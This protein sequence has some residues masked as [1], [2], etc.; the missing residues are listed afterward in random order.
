MPD[1]TKKCPFCAETIKAEA[2]VCRYC[3]NE[4]TAKTNENPPLPGPVEIPTFES[5][6]K[7]KKKKSIVKRLLLA[8]A[9]STVL[10]CLG[11]IVLVALFGSDSGAADG[12]ANEAAAEETGD[13]SETQPA[14]ATSAPKLMLEI[15][16]VTDYF[17][18]NALLSDTALFFYGEVVNSG[19]LP[20]AEPEVKITLLDSAG[21]IIATESSRADLP[22]T[23][24]MWFTGVLY[25]GEKAP[26]TIVVADPGE[27]ADFETELIYDEARSR[28]FD[29]HCTGFV[30]SR[31]TVGA[32][33]DI[34]FNY[35]V[36][37]EIENSS[38]KECGPVR[39][40]ITLYDDAMNVV[41]ST[42]YMTEADPFPIGDRQSFTTEMF[43][44]D[45][46]SSYSI[47]AR[48]IEK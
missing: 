18:S 20:I 11:L 43:A 35:R 38:G 28:D 29:E 41:G 12:S 9:A 16:T 6:T 44:W 22:L 27:W 37:G 21:N 30:I 15:V 36:S 7:P 32:I 39:L 8:G 40:T 47:L 19:D 2:I 24:S 48:A 4:L 31:D 45:E 25:P 14:T 33:S 26:F 23:L 34:L 17:D 46:V 10:V 13:N 5:A 1:E 3:G 42:V